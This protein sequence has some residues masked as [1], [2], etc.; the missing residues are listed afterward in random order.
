MALITWSD[1]S[2]LTTYLDTELNALAN[3]ANKIGAEIDNT[4]DKE[5]NMLLELYLGLQGGA[6]DSGAY[7]PVYIVKSVDGTNYEFGGD[8]LD[9]PAASLIGVF[10]LDAAATARYVGLEI[11][12]PPCKFKILV[13][14]ETGQ[15]LAG[16]LN[17]LKYRTYTLEVE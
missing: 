16:T 12:I 3:G 7:L 17:T 10:T 1:L 6:R 4:V 11:P 15:A 5:T 9:P 2:T 8:A 13:I 14:N